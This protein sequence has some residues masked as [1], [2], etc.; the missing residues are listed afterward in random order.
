MPIILKK[1]MKRNGCKHQPITAFV[2]P[3]MMSLSGKTNTS[4]QATHGN[5]VNTFS[6]IMK[7]N[8]R[9]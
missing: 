7:F 4:D 1:K 2:F 3:I 9:G 5:S 8:L 6:M